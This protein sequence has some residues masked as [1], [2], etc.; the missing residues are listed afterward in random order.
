MV[1]RTLYTIA[2]VGLFGSVNVSAQEIAATI[3]DILALLS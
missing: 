2:L 1:T 3:A